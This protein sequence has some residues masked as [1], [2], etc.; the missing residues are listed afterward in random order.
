MMGNLTTD[1]IDIAVAYPNVGRQTALG[2]LRG[3]VEEQRGY[4]PPPQHEL[5]SKALFKA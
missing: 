3:T 1:N 2:I 4:A 5:R